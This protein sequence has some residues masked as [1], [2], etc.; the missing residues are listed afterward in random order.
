MS[1]VCSTIQLNEL[2]R[3]FENQNCFPAAPRP[4]SYVK[5]PVKMGGGFNRARRPAVSLLSWYMQPS[6][7][8]PA[9]AQGSARRCPNPPY[10]TPYALPSAQGAPQVH[11]TGAGARLGALGGDNG[12]VVVARCTRALRG[13]PVI[14]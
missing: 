11:H 7:Q 2:A 10:G 3:A 6:C 13:S 5:R 14:R 1:H 4:F 12:A 8:P 9:R